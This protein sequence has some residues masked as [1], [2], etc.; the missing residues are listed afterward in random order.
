LHVDKLGYNDNIGE[1]N[2]EQQK[3]AVE[4]MANQAD[5]EAN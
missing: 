3:L 4:A 1:R 5:E 2:Q